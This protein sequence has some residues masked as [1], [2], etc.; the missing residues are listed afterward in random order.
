MKGHKDAIS[1]LDVLQFSSGMRSHINQASI[2]IVRNA[3]NSLIAST[4]VDGTVRIW[5]R[6]FE[7]KEDKKAVAAV[8]KS[9]AKEDKSKDAPNGAGLDEWK[10]IQTIEVGLQKIMMCSAITTR[11]D[12][13]GAPL[14]VRSTAP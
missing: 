1:S 9:T 4:S 7:A 10:C 12:K 11:T 14:I 13:N 5:M 2:Q 6:K 3:G 8:D